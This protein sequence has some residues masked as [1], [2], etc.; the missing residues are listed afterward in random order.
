MFDDIHNECSLEVPAATGAAA[1]ATGLAE[2][3]AGEVGSAEFPTTSTGAI[4]RCLLRLQPLSVAG[5]KVRGVNASRGSARGAN[6]SEFGNV[7][8]RVY[9]TMSASRRNP[10]IRNRVPY[11]QYRYHIHIYIYIYTYIY[12]Y[13]CTHKHTKYIHAYMWVFSCLSSRSSA[14]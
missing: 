12:I 14:V 13:M 10:T 7:G 11:Y 9:A 6:G 3:G 1:A 2:A 4:C 5:L 8:P